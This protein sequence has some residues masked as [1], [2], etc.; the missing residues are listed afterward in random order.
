MRDWE[1]RLSKRL[2]RLEGNQYV[3]DLVETTTRVFR[4]KIDGIDL[5]ELTEEDLE[6]IEQ[7][8]FEEIVQ[9]RTKGS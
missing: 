1:I 9:L 8:C 3:R 5:N 2:N 4:K 7:E 6:R